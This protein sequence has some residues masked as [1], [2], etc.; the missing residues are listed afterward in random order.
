M[1]IQYLNRV[2]ACEA[3]IHHELLDAHPLL[4]HRRWLEQNIKTLLLSKR[5]IK[6]FIFTGLV[7]SN[8]LKTC[9]LSI[10]ILN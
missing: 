8:G 10:E 6:Q 7:S 9:R 5:L 1:G 4:Y 2:D 3:G